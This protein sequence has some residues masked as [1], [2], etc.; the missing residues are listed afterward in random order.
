MNDELVRSLNDNIYTWQNPTEKWKLKENVFYLREW[1]L[2]LWNA[3]EKTFT[4][5]YT[6][7]ILDFISLLLE[8]YS[9]IETRWVW[10]RATKNNNH[11]LGGE[12]NGRME[13]L[14]SHT[15]NILRSIEITHPSAQRTNT[16]QP[17]TLSF[18]FS[19]WQPHFSVF[20]R[21]FILLSETWLNWSYLEAWN[22][23]L[24]IVNR[25]SARV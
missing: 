21:K 19:H 23:F 16:H 3:P 17:K 7:L 14:I 13:F 5:N 24:S 6:V 20:A 10:M 15:L 12:V 25:D 1:K 2:N 9:S 8:F 4:E 11:H 18:G 22:S